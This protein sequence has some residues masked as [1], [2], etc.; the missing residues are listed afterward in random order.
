MAV[1]LTSCSSVAAKENAPAQSVA[2]N[3]PVTTISTPPSTTTTTIKRAVAG[4]QLPPGANSIYVLGDSV[5]LGAQVQF[6]VALSGWRLTFDA[7]ESRRIDQGVGVVA[8]ASTP[9][10]RVLV[11]HLCTNWGGGDFRA[12]AEKLMSAAKGVERVVWV[13]CFPWSPSVKEANAAIRTLPDEFLNVV[14][15][16]WAP[17]ASTN[18]YTYDDH[19]HLKTAGAE[20]LAALVASTVGPPP[21]VS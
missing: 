20:A 15:A 12:M 17:L 7:K 11:V 14:V 9:I 16:D 3:E 18:G 8:A 21:T 19:L 2:P 4:S 5:T 13:T 10:T 6:P 1:L